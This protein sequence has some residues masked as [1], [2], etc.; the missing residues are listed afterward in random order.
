YTNSERIQQ[1]IDFAMDLYQ[2]IGC[3]V[4]NVAQRSI[5]ETAEIILQNI[6]ANN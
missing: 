6:L 2:K 4:I 1:E 5:E 3:S